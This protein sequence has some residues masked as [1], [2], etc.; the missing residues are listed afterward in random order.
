AAAAADR[1]LL[2]CSPTQEQAHAAVADELTDTAA[3]IADARANITAG[4]L[5]LPPGSLLIVDDAATAD[6]GVLADLAEH[7]AANQSGLI[8]LDTTG[9]TWPPQPSQR[10]L[11]L[12]HT[13]LPWTTT[14][15]SQTSSDVINRGTPPDLEPALVQSRRLYPT[16]LNDHLRASLTRADQL[17][18]TI[19]AAYRRH[20]DATWLR[21]R[22]RNTA[23]QTPEIGLTDD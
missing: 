18:T 4:Q 20:I 13:E 5:P 16:L 23:Q 21:R 22:G 9:Q 2:W 17:H 8:L 1:K 7:A 6:P 10:L 12:L 3:T 15:T 19:H 11:R 14:L